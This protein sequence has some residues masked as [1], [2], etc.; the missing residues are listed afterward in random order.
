MGEN[1]TTTEFSP[2]K[3]I[4]IANFTEY[5]N[6]TDYIPEAVTTETKEIDELPDDLKSGAK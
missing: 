4:V 5:S 2:S 6:F 1:F 3:D